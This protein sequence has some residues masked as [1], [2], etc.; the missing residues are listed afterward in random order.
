[1]FAFSNSG[2]VYKAIDESTQKEVVIKEGRPYTN[3][4]NRGLDAI[5]LIKK[6]H[7]LMSLLSGTEVA[8]EPLD[9]FP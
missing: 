3:I 4:S 6:E 9:F 1:M 8:A 7:R 5:Q 2:G